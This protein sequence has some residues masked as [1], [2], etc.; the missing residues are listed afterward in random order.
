MLKRKKDGSVET[1]KPKKKKCC[2]EKLELVIKELES[3]STEAT[4]LFGSIHQQQQ[5]AKDGDK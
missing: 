4:E 2:H 5:E 3:L 1:K